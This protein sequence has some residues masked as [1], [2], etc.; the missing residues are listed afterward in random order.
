MKYTLIIAVDK[1]NLTVPSQSIA[2]S[3]KM[4]THNTVRVAAFIFKMD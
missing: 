1:D 3:A 2:V 4:M